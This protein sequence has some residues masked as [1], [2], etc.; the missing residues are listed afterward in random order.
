[1]DLWQRIRFRLS[2]SLRARLLPFLVRKR[3]MAEVLALCDA[4]SRT[5]YAG[6][7]SSYICRRVR[8][9]TRRPWLMADRP[10]LRQGL[11]AMY[12]LQ[13]AGFRPEL[14][15]AVDPGSLRTDTASAHCWV[16]LGGE[17]VLSACPAG[18]ITIHTHASACSPNEASARTAAAA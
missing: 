4:G 10:C 13:A 11:L 18:M 14:R 5:P 16:C 8:K 9:A 15:F 2:L 17:P 3:P 7:T 12:Y 6:L 1:M